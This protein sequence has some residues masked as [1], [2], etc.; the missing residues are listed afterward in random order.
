MADGISGIKFAVFGGNYAFQRGVT[1]ESVTDPSF[2]S[3][4]VNTSEYAG[5]AVL[6]VF[7]GILDAAWQTYACELSY[8][9]SSLYYYQMGL[10][11]HCVGTRLAYGRYEQRA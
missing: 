1:R 4:N 5:L 10:T 11:P 9:Y 6:Y 3:L 2:Q 7:N 8:L